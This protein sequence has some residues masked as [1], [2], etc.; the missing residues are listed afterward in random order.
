MFPRSRATYGCII[1]QIFSGLEEPYSRLE[2]LSLSL[3]QIKS[4]FV[5]LRTHKGRDH[6]PYSKVAARDQLSVLRILAELVCM[7][8]MRKINFL[9][10]LKGGTA[11]AYLIWEKEFI[12]ILHFILRFPY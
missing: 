8:E 2:A 5:P 4:R 6:D 3:I 11:R 12:Y 7:S 1:I 9:S 10:I